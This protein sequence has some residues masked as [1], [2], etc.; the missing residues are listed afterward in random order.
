[1]YKVWELRTYNIGDGLFKLLH[2]YIFSLSFL[3][4]SLFL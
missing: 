2:I 1:M 4:T 3:N